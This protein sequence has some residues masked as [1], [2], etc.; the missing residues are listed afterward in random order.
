MVFIGPIIPCLGLEGYHDVDLTVTY[1][2]DRLADFV[3]GNG[4]DVLVAEVVIHALL[5]SPV[6]F[7]LLNE[8]RLVRCHEF[9][10]PHEGGDDE[11]NHTYES[12]CSTAA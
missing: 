1:V 9:A 7:P 5:D 12:E 11:Q 6:A 4:D 8:E 3:R 10:R 2:D